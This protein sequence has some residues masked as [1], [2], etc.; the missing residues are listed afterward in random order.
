[1]IKEST[2]VCL[3][4]LFLELLGYFVLGLALLGVVFTGLVVLFLL[5][6]FVGVCIGFL[7]P[8]FPSSFLSVWVMG[9]FLIVCVLMA[10]LLDYYDVF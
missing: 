1:M 4:N 3:K 6:Y 7:F 8:I 5:S 2:I 10:G 9:V